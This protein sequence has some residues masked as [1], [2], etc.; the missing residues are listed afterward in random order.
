[1]LKH[2][3]L[4]LETRLLDL[5]PGDRIHKGLLLIKDILLGQQP[6][7]PRFIFEESESLFK[8]ENV[9][10]LFKVSFYWIQF[11][12]ELLYSLVV[13]L[14]YLCTILIFVDDFTGSSFD[15]EII[16][17]DFGVLGGESLLTLFY[18]P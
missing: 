17:I 2:V 18:H 8:I 12:L 7:L 11:D 4:E 1:M 9:S 6:D 13:F 3:K 15:S 16:F 5:R 10:E 14:H